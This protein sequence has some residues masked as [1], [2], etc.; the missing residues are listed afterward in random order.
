MKGNAPRLSCEQCKHRKV[1]CDKNTPCSSCQANCLQ[2]VSVQRARLPRGRT[3]KIKTKATASSASEHDVVHIDVPDENNESLRHEQQSSRTTQVEKSTSGVGPPRDDRA[4]I[5]ASADLIESTRPRQTF[6]SEQ[7]KDILLE[8]YHERVDPLFKVTHWLAT[9]D[10]LRGIRAA[11]HNASS[12]SESFLER[13]IYLLGASLLTGEE[14]K[15]KLGRDRA[16]FLLELGYDVELL[17]SEAKFMQKPDLCGLQAF[18]IYLVRY[19]MADLSLPRSCAV[20][21][22]NFS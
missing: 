21:L 18:M 13:A 16:T 1:R 20:R 22:T 8:I 19:T 5:F 15:S 2:C 12:P 4:F 10:M 7:H 3:G 9:I 11:D 6:V 17:F 14:C